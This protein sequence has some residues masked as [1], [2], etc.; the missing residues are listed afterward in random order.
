MREVDEDAGEKT[1]FG[2]AEQKSQGIKVHGVMDERHSHADES[3]SDH[4]ARE[5]AT[6]AP[7]FDDHRAGNFQQK[8]ASEEDPGAEAKDAI[9]EAEF[10]RHLQ[11]SG[12]DVGAVE[13]GDDVEEG[14]VRQQAKRDAA[15]SAIRYFKISCCHRK[16][17]LAA[18][19]L[20]Y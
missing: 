19:I 5:P 17:L 13:K 7:F 14:E 8:V 11:G 15:A 16:A 20:R 9:V 4:D 1:G 3:P 6:R 18:S 2:Q 12:R 10:V